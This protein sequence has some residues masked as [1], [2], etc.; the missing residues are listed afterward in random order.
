MYFNIFASIVVNIC[1]VD[2]HVLHRNAYWVKHL[3]LGH[4]SCNSRSR[5]TV[6]SHALSSTFSWFKFWWVF[7]ARAVI[8][9]QISSTL[10][11]LLFSFDQSTR[12]EETLMQ[13][14]ASQL[15]FSFDQGFNGRFPFNG[16]TGQIR[17]LHL[18]INGKIWSMFLKCL[19]KMDLILML[20]KFSGQIGREPKC[21]VFHSTIWPFWAVW[22][23]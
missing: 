13:T 5:F 10:M 12:V 9:S 4:E 11:Q 21:F 8:F 3:S 17:I 2:N 6:N 1:E 7:A 18:C 14:L 22:P 16:L 20:S 19:A 15:S 23:C